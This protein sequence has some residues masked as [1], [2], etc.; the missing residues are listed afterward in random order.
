MAFLDIKNVRIVGISAGVP[1]RVVN[2]LGGGR[3]YPVTIQQSTS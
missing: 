2:N 3:I 1:R